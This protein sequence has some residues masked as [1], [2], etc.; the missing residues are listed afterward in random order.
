[1]HG[2]NRYCDIYQDCFGFRHCFHKVARLRRRP[3]PQSNDENDEGGKDRERIHIDP[4]TLRI[5]KAQL[6]SAEMN[7]FPLGE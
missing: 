7:F 2:I 6:W 1:M 4:E 3:E 5:Q